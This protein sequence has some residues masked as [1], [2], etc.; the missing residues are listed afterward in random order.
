MPYKVKGNCSVYQ[1]IRLDTDEVFY[2]GIAKVK[3]RPYSKEYR[4]KHWHNI[5]SKVG[6]KVEIIHE[7]LT[8]NEAQEI[9][10]NLIKQYGRKDLN[11]GILVNMTDG[12]EGICGYKHTDEWK[13][14]NSIR[15]KGKTIPESQR[16][17]IKDYMS[18]RTITNDFK[19]KVSNGVKRY[20]DLN[21]RVPKKET[22]KKSDLLWV[23]KDTINKRVFKGF[24]N[25]F[26]NNG[27]SLGRYIKPETNDIMSKK[28]SKWMNNGFVERMVLS[29]EINKQL[30]NNWKFGRLK[31]KQ[32]AVLS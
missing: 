11:S 24:L 22:H 28:G 7:G 4:N 23:N 3:N 14:N 29:D 1:H 15:N 25:E 9:E 17:I 30:S 8:W 16:N 2:V 27:W 10:R 13:L 32:N 20:Y 26:I 12:G 31:I 18:N 6:Y 21:G 5:V 19:E